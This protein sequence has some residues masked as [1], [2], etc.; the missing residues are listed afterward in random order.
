[1]ITMEAEVPMFFLTCF[2]VVFALKTL[3][4]SV[5]LFRTARGR[6][7]S[8]SSTWLRSF[9]PSGASPRSCSG[10]AWSWAPPP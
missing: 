8:F 3:I 2:L 7:R 10:A 4:G 6:C 1:M 9:S 5:L